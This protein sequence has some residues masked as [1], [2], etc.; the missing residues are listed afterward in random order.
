MRQK[1]T[2]ADVV[3]HACV[4]WDELKVGLG[5][6]RGTPSGPQPVARR[7]VVGLSKVELANPDSGSSLEPLAMPRPRIGCDVEKGLGGSPLGGSCSLASDGRR[8]PAGKAPPPRPLRATVRRRVKATRVDLV[9]PLEPSLSAPKAIHELFLRGRDR[10]VALRPPSGEA[11]VDRL[12]PPRAAPAVARGRRWAGLARR[13]RCAWGA[14]E[15]VE[16]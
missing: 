5:A 15:D 8:P 16:F 3:A 9:P 10:S 14:V 6:C 1:R 4:V 11:V 13:R 7:L 2:I 12:G